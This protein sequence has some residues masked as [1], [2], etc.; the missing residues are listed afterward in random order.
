MNMLGTH[1]PTEEQIGP[2][3]RTWGSAGAEPASGASSPGGGG[4]VR[5]WEKLVK[6]VFVA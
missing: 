1:L 2:L 6:P 3:K 4:G 5:E